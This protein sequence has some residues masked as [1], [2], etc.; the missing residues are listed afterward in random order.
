MKIIREAANPESFF[1]SDP[2]LALLFLATMGNFLSHI[3]MVKKWLKTVL[4]LIYQAV[5]SVDFIESK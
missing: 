1:G 2:N 5:S 3:K 4:L